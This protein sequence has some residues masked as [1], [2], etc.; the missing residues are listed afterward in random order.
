ML[1]TGELQTFRKEYF[2]YFLE[3]TFGFSARSSVGA[4]DFKE[5]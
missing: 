3:M 5:L 4:H 1:H 2:C